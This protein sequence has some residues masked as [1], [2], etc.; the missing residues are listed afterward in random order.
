MKQMIT[1]LLTTMALAAFATPATALEGRH[2][3]EF[4]EGLGNKLSER[5]SQEFYDG[6]GNKLSE[7]TS[8]EFYDGLG[9]KLSDRHQESFE[10]GLGNK[11]HYSDPSFVG[12]EFRG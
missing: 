12:Q 11:G 3:E 10:D 7:R 5:T 9:N 8:Q 6:L 4:Y 1:A 2:G